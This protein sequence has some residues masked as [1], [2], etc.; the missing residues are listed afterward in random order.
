MQQRSDLARHL[1]DVF[2]LSEAEANAYVMAMFEKL[3]E[4][5]ARGEDAVI[6]EFG[7]FHIK[8]V[9]GARRPNPGTGIYTDFPSSVTVR[10]KPSNTLKDRLNHRRGRRKK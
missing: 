4:G 5:F 8:E 9:P 1:C 10:W 6:R 2:F 7:S 3:T